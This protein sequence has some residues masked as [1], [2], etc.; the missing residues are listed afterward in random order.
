MAHA[1][2]IP[3]HDG[4]SPFPRPVSS[5]PAD[6]QSW[7]DPRTDEPH[8]QVDCAGSRGM[9]WQGSAGGMWDRWA[10]SPVLERVSTPLEGQGHSSALC[11]HLV[12]SQPTTPPFSALH[13][14]ACSSP[15][16]PLSSLNECG[17][18][19]PTTCAS[20]SPPEAATPCTSACLAPAACTAWTA[21]PRRWVGRH[22]RGHLQ[23]SELW[24]MQQ[25]LLNSPPTL[26]SCLPTSAQGLL[27]SRRPRL[28]ALA[29]CAF[30]CHGVTP[31][32]RRA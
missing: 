29:S 18:S 14:P 15:V 9:A 6:T 20:P 17:R 11:Q 13:A 2:A 19:T 7:E 21:T 22:A 25:C 16:L 24:A 4:P 27:P 3:H 1:R 5:L 8:L 26:P 28:Q 32:N 30:A 31:I 12:A 10:H 23:L